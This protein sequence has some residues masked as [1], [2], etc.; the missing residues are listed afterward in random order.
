[1]ADLF[2][3]IFAAT[4]LFTRIF[5]YLKPTPAPTIKGLRLHH[6]MFGVVI[7]AVGFLTNSLV[8][9]A[10]GLGL[11]ADELAYLAIGGKTHADN[12]SARSLIGL[13][14]LVIAVF[15]FRSQLISWF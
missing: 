10:V 14:I 2:F 11:F 5:L 13:L 6:W 12:Y 7:A 3:A 8:L 15:I 4:I 9:W 1:M